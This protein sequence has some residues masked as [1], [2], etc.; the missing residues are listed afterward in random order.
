MYVWMLEAW[1]VWVSKRYEPMRYK[2]AVGQEGFGWK[3]RLNKL[4]L[5]GSSFAT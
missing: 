1:I 2:G 3:L 4:A 5:L